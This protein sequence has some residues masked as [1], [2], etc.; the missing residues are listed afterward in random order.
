M[1]S[2]NP[3]IYSIVS[4][5]FHAL[6]HGLRDQSERSSDLV[7]DLAFGESSMTVKRLGILRVT[8]RLPDKIDVVVTG[9]KVFESPGEWGLELSPSDL[10]SYTNI[11]TE[12]VSCITTCPLWDGKNWISTFMEEDF[13]SWVM[14]TETWTPDVEATSTL[15]I[16]RAMEM[17]RTHVMSWTEADEQLAELYSRA[18]YEEN[19]RRTN[20]AKD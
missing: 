7:M 20:P 1:R 17:V 4:P 9:E 5:A 12:I 16:T 19:I 3:P 10:I 13:V 18:H 8:P 11:A 14:N 2:A 15:L 6:V